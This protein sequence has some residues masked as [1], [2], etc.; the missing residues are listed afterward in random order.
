M[1]EGEA[2]GNATTNR[3]RGAQRETEVC[4][5]AEARQEAEVNAPVDNRRRQHNEEAA[6]QG[7]G[8]SR[9]KAEAPQNGSRRHQRSELAAWWVAETAA[10]GRGWHRRR[11]G[12]GPVEKNESMHFLEKS[13]R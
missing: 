6:S 10:R 8:T 7:E 13:H 4:R 9:Q 1:A 11:R 12:G 3:T 2:L 5:E